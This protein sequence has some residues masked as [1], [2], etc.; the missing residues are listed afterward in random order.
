MKIKGA[1]AMFRSHFAG[2]SAI[3]SVGEA[4]RKL[5]DQL[6]CLDFASAGPV[7]TSFVPRGVGAGAVT[8]SCSSG[9]YVGWFGVGASR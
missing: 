1:G 9:R 4:A 8:V 7:R 3:G 5:A 2:V 6:L